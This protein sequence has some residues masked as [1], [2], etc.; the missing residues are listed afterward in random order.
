MHGDKRSA[1]ADQRRTG[2]GQSKQSG[3]VTVAKVTKTQGRK[4]EVA[5]TLLTDF[6][7]RFASRKRLFAWAG[8][9]ESRRELELQEHWF[10]KGQVVLKFSGVDSISDAEAL[11]GSEIQIPAGE[12][13]ELQD[14]ALYVSDLIGCMLL[15]SGR[16]IGRIED[17]QFGGGE[18]P[19][20][21]VKGEKEYLIPFAAS[22][23]E[24]IELEQ[25]RISVKLPPGMLEL[26]APLSQEEKQEQH[27]QD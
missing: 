12:R 23:I 9:G 5:A 26:D 20:L 6:P 13:A 7:E 22:F 27:R 24:K 25:K 10:H 14:G 15:D 17:V 11:L 16:E 3:F 21:L 2:A 8:S 19:L 18:A 4:G 1:G